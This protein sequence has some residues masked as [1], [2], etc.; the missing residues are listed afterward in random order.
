MKNNENAGFLLGTA[1]ALLS[2]MPLGFLI[3]KLEEAI[4]NFKIDNNVESRLSLEAAAM[5]ISMKM[6]NMAKAKKEGKSEMDISLDLG[7]KIT[8][9]EKW[10]KLN[11]INNKQ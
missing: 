6:G 7:N 2:L 1:G 10:S 5:A 9:E 3:E 11:P 4:T 8:E